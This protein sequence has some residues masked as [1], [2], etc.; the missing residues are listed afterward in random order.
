MNTRTLQSALRRMLLVAAAVGC[1]ARCI[2]AY[3][4]MVDAHVWPTTLACD[5]VREKCI[6]RFRF[7]SAFRAASSQ[8]TNRCPLLLF[9][10]PYA[11]FRPEIRSRF[12]TLDKTRIRFFPFVIRD[13][14]AEFLPYF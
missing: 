2:L 7:W 12:C 3:V 5:M 6:S 13:L 8:L 10:S 4:C 9:P 14:M 1:R 11:S